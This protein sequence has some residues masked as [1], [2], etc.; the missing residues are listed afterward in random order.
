[1]VEHLVSNRRSLVQVPVILGSFKKNEKKSFP[2]KFCQTNAFVNRKGDSSEQMLC[3]TFF[4][5]GSEFKSW[6]RKGF[7]DESW[8]GFEL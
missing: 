2:L 8:T 3:K 1:M 5:K 7:W 6:L 4:T